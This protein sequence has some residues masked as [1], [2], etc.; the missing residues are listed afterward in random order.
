M[1]R[2]VIIRANI[3]ALLIVFASILF[4]VKLGYSEEGQPIL[5]VPEPSLLINKSAAPK[6]RRLSTLKKSDHPSKIKQSTLKSRVNRGV[7]VDQLEEINT[8]ELG[9]IS[10]K[11]EAFG[12][13]VWKGTSFSL[14]EKLLYRLPF[15]S[16]SEVMRSLMRRLLLSP[17]RV[18]KGKIR[19]EQGEFIKSRIN[20]L[21][22]LG[23]IASAQSLLRVIPNSAQDH[24][25][26]L[27]DVK[28]SLLS[29]NYSRAC[30]VTVRQFDQVQDPF[31]QEVLNFCRII[32]GDKDKATLGVSLMR[33]LG[34]G[35]EKY[36]SLIDALISGETLS[37]NTLT[38][39]SPLD[40]AIIKEARIDLPTSAANS[41]EVNIVRALAEDSQNPVLLRLN[42]A[43]RANNLGIFPT[44]ALRTMFENVKFSEVE[45]ENPLSRAEVRFGPRIRALLYL[46]ARS[47]RVPSAQ[48]E[49]I[50]RA[51]AIGR[52]ENKYFS[53]VRV[54]G[55]LIK[56]L[57]PTDDLL[58]FAAEAA[59]ALL[60]I[61]E[62]EKSK[63]W[64]ELIKRAPIKSIERT[65]SLALLQ[66]FIKIIGLSNSGSYESVDF[67]PWLDAVRS[68]QKLH[69][70]LFFCIIDGLGFQ[71][72]F[73]IWEDTIKQ[74]S[75]KNITFPDAS[76][77][78]H[79]SSILDRLEKISKDRTTLGKL[80]SA[81]PKKPLVSG[82]I[83]VSNPT[84]AV[85]KDVKRDNL[86]ENKLGEAIL[87]ILASVGNDFH[88]NIN[89]IVL[90]KVI[91]VLVA[92]GLK[93]EAQLLAL[94]V[95]LARGF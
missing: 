33:E 93:K 12:L 11:E 55:S 7:E 21:T 35:N 71:V 87:L 48:A 24:H 31:L 1:T 80:I 9:V 72:P 91:K 89:P 5:L 4:A 30:L 39:L 74:E 32:E 92:V 67:K 85:L 28:L 75:Y 54:F 57:S 18:P 47:N 82:T 81:S 16:Q 76:I 79:L 94:E 17:A 59:R 86:S 56:N 58:W 23:E 19:G 46:T 51:L 52:Y 29:F 53:T 37:I 62:W 60:V 38:N 95:L 64:Y 84:G 88:L 50:Y 3:I 2:F 40:L 26:V 61:G 63:L 6:K 45:L 73:Q 27:L 65:Q 78:V 66:P 44:S 36:F 77:W 68:D 14:V 25:L 43:E 22:R 42:A 69:S 41:N 20:A 15:A 49:A 34:N 13:E 83:E 8:D 90:R 70:D 10:A